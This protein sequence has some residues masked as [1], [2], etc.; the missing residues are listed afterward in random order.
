MLYAPRMPRID[1]K[2]NAAQN[3][4]EEARL[5]ALVSYGLLDTGDE[6]ELDQLTLL[7]TQILDVPYGLV[8]LVDRDRQWSKSSVGIDRVETPREFAFCAHAILESDIF[9]I[10]DATK[11]E[12]FVDNPLVTMDP[13]VR[14]YAGAPLSMP[15]GF[16]LGTLRVV[17]DKPR[18]VDEEFL[19]QLGVMRDAVVTH[20]EFR[21]HRLNPE[22]VQPV[23]LLCAWCKKVH[24]TPETEEALWQP[25]DDYLFEN[26]NISHGMCP[27]CRA[28]QLEQ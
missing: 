14:F 23:T 20:L 7:T 26:T 6:P 4:A 15:G 11:D 24:A 9:V 27:T 18:V 21:R 1:D 3:M 8:N 12:R 2:K 16:R 13:N 28:E 17:S 5:D 10:N 25:I 22:L 19:F